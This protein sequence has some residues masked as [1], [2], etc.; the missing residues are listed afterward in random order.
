MARGC[1]G[2]KLPWYGGPPAG[3]LGE[4]QAGKEKGDAFSST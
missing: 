2:D 3:F 1:Q 4:L